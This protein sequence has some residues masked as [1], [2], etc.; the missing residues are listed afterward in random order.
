MFFSTT[1]TQKWLCVVCLD[2]WL[3]FYAYAKTDYTNR[4]DVIVKRRFFTLITC[5]PELIFLY[6]CTHL[7]II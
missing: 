1:L 7:Q 6:L 2:D 3:L 5:A 4:A